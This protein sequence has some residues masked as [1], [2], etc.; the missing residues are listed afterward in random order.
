MPDADPPLPT[1]RLKNTLEEMRASVAEQGTNKGLA[2]L[3]QKAML[4]FM[5]LLMTL[6]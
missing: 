4:S 5:S 2:G 1:D 3:L 6:L